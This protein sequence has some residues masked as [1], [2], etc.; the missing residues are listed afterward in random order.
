MNKQFFVMIVSS[1]VNVLLAVL[2][3]VIGFVFNSQLLLADGIHSASDLLTDI[4]ALVGLKMARKPKDEDHPFGHGNLE[5]ASSLTVAIII[6]FM[7]YELI[8]ELI[9]D[10]FVVS[11][12]V[13]YYVLGVSLFTFVCKILLSSFVYYH[14]IKLDSITLKNSA[15]ESRV[16][17][18]STLVVIVGLLLTSAGI[19]HN[20]WW[21]VYAEKCAT[22]LVIVML[23]KAAWTI[24]YTAVVGIAGTYA[25][26]SIKDEFLHR[27][28]TADFPFE[29]QHIL[30]LKQGIHYAVQIHILLD[31][32][33]PL[34]EAVIHSKNLRN[35]LF[36][37]ERIQKVSIEMDVSK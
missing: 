23:I 29:V 33:M 1:S 5:Y 37:D 13:S 12:S 15:I 10:W 2:K 7:A 6:F 3:I 30:V 16:D 24:Y 9:A 4:F 31:K 32:H 28:T 26:D 36:E 18:Y 35:F 21:L 8:K 19:E 11:A 34:P 27:I 22:I 17:A 20:I 14:A 25:D